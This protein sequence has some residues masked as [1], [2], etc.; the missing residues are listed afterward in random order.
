M[1]N[2]KDY[3]VLFDDKDRVVGAICDGERLSVYIRAKGDTGFYPTFWDCAHDYTKDQAYIKF[4]SGR[5]IFK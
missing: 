5:L 1:K 2:W 3:K 4:R